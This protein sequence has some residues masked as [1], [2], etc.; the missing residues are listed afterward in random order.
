M[1]PVRASWLIEE[2]R[3]KRFEQLAEHAGVSADVF[4]ERVIDHLD[5]GLTDRGLPKWWPALEPKDGELLI[6]TA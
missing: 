4:L 5:E 6:D 2:E 1:R 3:K